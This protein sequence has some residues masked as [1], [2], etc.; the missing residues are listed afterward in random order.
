VTL[1]AIAT[2]LGI[3]HN[4]VQMIGSLDDPKKGHPAAQCL[5]SHHS[6]DLGKN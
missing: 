6:F 5:A 4:A 1:D 3:G 2:K